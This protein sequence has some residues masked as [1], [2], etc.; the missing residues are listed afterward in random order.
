VFL[1]RE[2]IQAA[3]IDAELHVLSDGEKAIGFF[4]E[5]DG[6]EEAP[7]PALVILDINLP[8]R[9][10][11]EVLEHMRKS[12]KCGRTPVLIVSTSDSPAE[13]GKM[14]RLGADAYFRKPSEYAD[15]MKLGEMVQ[16]LL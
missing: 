5:A 9:N 13:R 2:A 7:C 15:F 16:A 6:S 4:D 1:I 3:H 12:A 11:G 14:Q 8:K 10:G